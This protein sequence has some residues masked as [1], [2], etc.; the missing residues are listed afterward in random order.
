[1]KEDTSIRDM[2]TR[3]TSIV[4]EF[5]TLGEIIPRN[6]LVRKILSVLP[7]SWES[8][9]NAI[10]EAKNLQM[11]TINEHIGNLKTYEMKKKKDYERR[12]SK[13]E[14]S[15]V[16]KADN[17]DSDS[18]SES[19]GDDEPGDTSMIVIE[20]EVVEYDSIFAL[21]A[22]YDV[23]E[24]DDDDEA[25][26]GGSVSFGNDKKRYILEVGTIGRTLTHS[27]ENVYYVNG[28]KY[29]LLSVYQIC[30]KGNK[31]E[32]LSKSCTVT[33]L[34]TGEVVLIAKGFKNIYVANFDSLNGGDLTYFAW[35]LFL[36]TKEETF[37]VF[38][39]FV[40]QIQVGMNHNIVS[41]RSDR[42]TDFDNAKFDEFCAENGMS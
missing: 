27:I 24:D 33:K 4:N 41:I 11:L 29:N 26:Q 30:D 1:M 32:F 9:A 36:R 13:K 10:M 6:K 18:S 7:G 25:L 20:S 17:S 28:L 38:A 22:K 3:F 40:K 35:T 16:L 37:Q 39:A 5:H 31:V 21:M 23:D 15:L 12:E 14:K 19:E 34:I 42:D 2:H 8:K